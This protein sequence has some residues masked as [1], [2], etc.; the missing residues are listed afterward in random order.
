MSLIPDKTTTTRIM[1][2]HLKKAR[3]LE[4]KFHGQEDRKSIKPRPVHASLTHAE[5]LIGI[6][7]TPSRATFSFEVAVSPGFSGVKV[8]LKLHRGGTIL[9]VE[10]RF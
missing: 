7:P 9:H 5:K 3:K 10:E 2:G 8:S 6:F 4:G 1:I